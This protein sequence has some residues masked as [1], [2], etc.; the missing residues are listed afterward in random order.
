[1]MLTKGHINVIILHTLNL[2]NKVMLRSN[3]FGLS[4]LQ[5]ANF[6]IILALKIFF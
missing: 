2:S 3:P 5:I 6:K 1:M 4:H